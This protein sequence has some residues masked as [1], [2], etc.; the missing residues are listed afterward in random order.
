MNVLV[1]G[2][3]GFIGKNL[4]KTLN[5]TLPEEVTIY[6]L[7]NYS[8][9]SFK[10]RIH[11]SDR[12]ISVHRDVRYNFLHLFNEI[13]IDVIYHLACPASPP[14]YQRS[15][16]YTHETG[17]YGL[18]NVLHLAREKQCKVVFS[19]TS[20]VYGDPD[21][22]EQ[23]EDY[24]GRVHTMGPRAC[25]D[26]SKRMGE[27]ICWDYHKTLGLDIKVARIFNTYGPYMDPQDGR[28][29]SNFINQSLANS[30]LTIYGDGSQTR[31]LCYVSDT[32]DALIRL[33]NTDEST[34]ATPINVGNP[35]ELTV[36][37]IAE[38]I[39]DL[40][41]SSSELEYHELPVHDPAKRKPCIKR[42]K[43]LL[44]WEPKVN[45]NDGLLET[46]EYFK[47]LKS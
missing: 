39:K 16:L 24:T 8:S 13:D 36:L 29:I 34:A 14:I 12:V 31:S 18:A 45:L 38:K 40:T 17:I 15:F 20:E 47:S 21:I 6:S 43:E 44:D 30:P 4:V 1:T 5:D 26:E 2:G 32:V 28:I 41:D 33:A 46:I 35:V 11:W 9:S 10:N 19:S 22:D 42:A 27:T 37:E 23:N 25:Y 7:D 3:N